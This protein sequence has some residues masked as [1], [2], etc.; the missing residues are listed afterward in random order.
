MNLSIQQLACELAKKICERAE[1]G[2]IRDLDIM[3]EDILNDC[4]ETARSILQVMICHLNKEIRDDK[5]WRK[6]N[7]LVIK[8]KDRPRG[9]YTALGQIEFE[10]DYFL[11]KN[12]GS[13]VSI[14]DQLLGIKKRERVG[15]AVAANLVS[16]AADI[17][18]AKSS[19]IVT[20]GAVS[21]QTVHNLIK[22]MDVPEIEQEESPRTVKELHIYA[23]EDHAHMQKPG[24]EK[25]KKS[26]I[27]PLVTVTEGM[28]K[29]SS[30]RNKTIHP[31]H[32]SD[33]DFD[34]K[35]LWKSVEG[36][37]DKG[38]EMEGLEKIYV[39][40][41]GGGWI[42]N[43]LEAFAQTIH[44][45]DGFHFYKE[46]RKISRM[47]PERH[48]RVALLSAIKKDDRRRVDEYIK[49]L[50]EDCVG[51]E[52]REKIET[53]ATYLLG[54]WQEIRRR[55]VQ[56]DIPGSCTEGLVS[57]VLSE[58]FSRDP[59]GWSEEALGKLVM[60]RI[61]LKNGGRLTKTHFQTQNTDD[62]KYSEY[63]DK[64][65]EEHLEGAIDYSIFEPGHPTFDKASGTQIWISKLGK[66]T[67][68]L[69]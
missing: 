19:D 22:K 36:F 64:F 48:V 35:N 68:L 47:L 31:V 25:G 51:K 38:Y 17:S 63:A 7:G 33:K 20:G 23:D 43:G 60:A 21:R 54:N 3:A 62:E 65:I 49:S 5:E 14:L 44:V 18:Y 67:N 42:K 4:K 61:Y 41:D 16:K 12:K 34:T 37:I 13:H 8:D 2:E 69:S 45:M 30:R 46:L 50:L 52:E 15:A 56:D 39:H 27:I 53:F 40:G 11:D 6:E 29:E 1:K 57:H 28:R 26:K 9:I 55:I 58:R 59:I 66:T 24:K 10:R 32:F